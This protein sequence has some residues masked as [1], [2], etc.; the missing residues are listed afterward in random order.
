[1]RH[2]HPHRLAGDLDIL[3]APV[4]LIRL[5][6]ME[7]QRDER[8][9]AV[10]GIPA[11][12]GRPACPIAADGI[13]GAFKAFPHQQIM[14][15]RHPQPVPSAARR[16]LDQQ[17]VQAFL[18]RPDPRQRLNPAL[19]RE[20]AFRRSDRLAHNLARKPQ[21]PRDRLDRLPTRVLPPDPN[22][23]LHYQH[24]DLAT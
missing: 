24:P 13:I 6:R 2:L 8:R 7:Q 4:E 16:V 18:K 3:M 14:D 1:M 20:S 19:I 10:T 12:L 17:R 21:I 5:A 9:S 11:P 22:N 23:R 15:P